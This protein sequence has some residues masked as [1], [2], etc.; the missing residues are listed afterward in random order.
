[1]LT[2]NY[3]LTFREEFS[4][5]DAPLAM[6]DG[7]QFS[8]T[9]AHWGGLRNFAD[10]NEQQTYV[11]ASFGG[12]DAYD[13]FS[14]AS[15]ILTITAE[16]TPAGLQDDVS[17]PYVSGVLETSGGSAADG[18]R[19]DTGFW[20]QYGYWEMRAELPEGQGLWPAFWL[21]GDVEVDIM[22]V[23]GDDPWTVHN[24]TH[25]FRSGTQVST[26]NA[27]AVDDTS[28]G[29]HTYGL[30][31]TADSLDFYYD[32]K[33][34]T[35][36]DGEAFKD[37]GPS[38]LVV[39]L[40]VGGNWGGN[41]DSTTEFPAEMKIDYIR[42][43]E[44]DPNGSPIVSGD[45]SGTGTDTGSGTDT[46]TSQTGTNSTT[47]I[48]DGGTAG[49]DTQVG[50]AGDDWLAGAA[51]NDILAGNKGEDGLSGNAGDDRLRGGT[52]DDVLYGDAGNDYLAGGTGND[53]IYGGAGNDVMW[54]G[55]GSDTF[56]RDGNDGQDVIRDFSS[57]ADHIRLVGVSEADVSWSAVESGGGT[58]MQVSLGDGNTILLQHVS[59]LSQSDFIFA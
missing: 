48:Y 58:A 27:A 31:W 9:L 17:T 1:M 29:F 4:D 23:L 44:A 47:V 2:D 42:A 49:A 26:T 16:E 55:A 39:N 53:V 13:P 18:D 3:S 52:A 34:T 37:L 56:S 15:G 40:A 22:E 5:P 38:F 19:T 6:E 59:E 8:T 57:G 41:P 25:D 45:T 21:V 11:D 24:S 32:G 50:N 14:V 28:D 51:G 46:G 36:L 30:E 35:S 33:V 12:A 54:G 43:Y 20:Q 10:N 7:G